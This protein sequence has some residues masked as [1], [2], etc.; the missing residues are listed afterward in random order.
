VKV[1]YLF[2]LLSAV[3]SSVGNSISKFAMMDMPSLTVNCIAFYSSIPL[4]IFLLKG[5]AVRREVWSAFT[6]PKLMMQFGVR[7]IFGY[8]GIIAFMLSLSSGPIS[9][10]TALSGTQPI[11]VLILSLIATS[12]FPKLIHEEFGKKVLGAKLLALL[13]TVIG[14]LL[15]SL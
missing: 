4:Y 13:L 14:I 9:L 5:A 3:F 6:N 11:F 15:V 7:G 8:L 2:A 10:V 12:L 1:A